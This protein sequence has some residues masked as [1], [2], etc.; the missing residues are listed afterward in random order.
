MAQRIRLMLI[1]RKIARQEG[2]TVDETD[3]SERISEK[4][5]EFRTTKEAL[6][7]ELEEGVAMARLKDMLL[8]ESTLEYLTEIRR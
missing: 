6:K 2:I 5:G 8:A 1:L 3:V 7:K 4:A